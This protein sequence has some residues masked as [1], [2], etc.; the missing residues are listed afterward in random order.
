MG[1]FWKSFYQIPFNS[2]RL[3]VFLIVLY[4]K[5]AEKQE[6]TFDESGGVMLPVNNNVP[7]LRGFESTKKYNG[8]FAGYGLF[9][10]KII[11][12]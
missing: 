1:L 8:N 4:Q 11:L 9:L 5:K 10:L 7:E 6:Q 12:Y 2:K 3:F